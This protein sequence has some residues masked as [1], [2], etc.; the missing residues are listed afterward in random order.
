LLRNSKFQLDKPFTNV[1]S[2]ALS[3]EDQKL[4]RIMIYEWNHQLNQSQHI[5]L[6]DVSSS[7][8]VESLLCLSVSNGLLSIKILNVQGDNISSIDINNINELDQLLEQDYRQTYATSIKVLNSPSFDKHYVTTVDKENFDLTR[9]EN[10]GTVNSCF[11]DYLITG[12]PQ[13]KGN[14]KV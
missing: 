14:Y 9:F 5:G 13:I 12:L 6:I 10:I 11:V 1:T 2:I 7:I 3:K 4:M 8:T